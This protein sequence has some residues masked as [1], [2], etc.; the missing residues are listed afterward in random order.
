MEEIKN[1]VTYKSSA[2]SGKTYTLVREFLRI[3]IESDNPSRY[4]NIL[5]ITFTNKAANEMKKRVL[6]NL[7]ELSNDEDSEL[8]IQFAK[9]FKIEKSII[10]SKSKQIL[11]SVLHNYSDLKILTIDKFTHK[12]IRAFA[13]DLGLNNDFEVKMESDEVLKEAIDLLIS[14][15][16]SD[17]KISKVLLEYLNKHI[18]QE[19]TWKI[20]DNLF[21]FSKELLKED[22]ESFIERLRKMNDEELEA[23]KKFILKKHKELE[24]QIS[25]LGKYNLKLI[26]SNGIVEEDF[27]GKTVFQ[28]FKRISEGDFKDINGDSVRLIKAIEENIWLKGGAS[29]TAKANIKNISD[30]LRANYFQ[31][32]DVISEFYLFKLLQENVYNL[33]LIKEIDESIENIKEEGNILMI[34]DFNKLISDKIKNQPAPFIYEKIG[35]RYKNIMIDEFQDTSVMQWHNLLPLIDNSLSIGEKTLLVGDAKQAIYRFR[36]GKVEQF[37][38][39]PNIIDKT[40]DHLLDDKEIALT[41]NHK[42]EVLDTNYRSH[43]QVIEFNNLFFEKLTAHLN[44]EKQLIYKG[45]KQEST[46]KNEGYVEVSFIEADKDEKEVKNLEAIKAKIEECLADGFTQK[47]ITILVNKNTTGALISSYLIEND[48]QVVTNESLLIAEDIEVNFVFNFLKYIQNNK[49]NHAKLELIKFFFENEK[50]SP[51][52]L[53]YAVKTNN[54]AD[55]KLE[56]LFRILVPDFSLS[57]I[58]EMSLYDM[59][60]TISRT[61]LQTESHT[62]A[63]LIKFL[64]VIHSYSTAVNDLKSFIDYFDSKKEKLS[65]ETPDSDAIS[66]MSVHKS[67]G[68]QFPVVISAFTN[69]TFYPGTFRPNVWVNLEEQYLE[70]PVGILNLKKDIEKTDY[71]YLA[72]ID[73]ENAK[74]DKFNMLYVTLTRAEKRLYVICDADI[75][76]K[77]GIPYIDRINSY[78]YQICSVH[79][80]FKDGNLIIGERKIHIQQTEKQENQLVLNKTISTN[81]REKIRISKQYQELWGDKSYK[82]KIA[83]GN[84]IHNILSIVNSEKDIENAIQ[85]YVNQGLIKTNEIEMYQNEI[86]EIISING[87][88]SWFDENAKV[89]NEKEIIAKDGKL[90]RPDKIIVLKDKTIVLDF[91]T[92]EKQSTYSKQLTNYGNLLEDMNYPNIEKYLLFTK[93]RELVQVN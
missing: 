70:I 54:R 53:K 39:L 25:E 29:S 73:F 62:N 55:I 7:K 37:V 78:I 48:F 4:R 30:E 93:E 21:D 88:E 72:E 11:Q 6:S 79:Q 20:E 61:F 83:Y 63:F 3:V 34:S 18:D 31:M 86:R 58:Y 14:K 46:G 43:N 33:I 77:S 41:N 1:F 17:E 56:E 87:V 80:D 68:L 47:D 9:E 49:D 71:A 23:S 52:L 66:I 24:N 84:L 45:Q 19:Q 67:K 40:D 8:L 51:A 38:M 92:G 27:V 75:A 15:A 36:G 13:N 10:K 32:Q 64:D 26:N 12:I 85:E 35:E 28:I 76:P 57:Q 82:G 89:L 16:G 5:A 65:L 91:K 50:Y 42:N 2:G 22:N 74:L 81:W 44:E 90:Y 69:W 59:A 60:E